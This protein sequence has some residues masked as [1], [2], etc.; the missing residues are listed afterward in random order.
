MYRERINDISVISVLDIRK[1]KKSGKYPVRIQVAYKGVQ[2]Y[3]NTGKDLTKE[4]WAKLPNTRSAELLKLRDSIKMYFDLIVG[5]VEE[6]TSKGEYSFDRLTV[7]I[8]KNSGGTLNSAFKVKIQELLEE[9]RIG[10]MGYYKDCLVSVEKYAG[11]NI[12]F[13]DVNIQ[14]LNKFERFLLKNEMSYASIGMRM[15]GIRT[16]MNIAKNEGLIK[17]IQ[18]PFGRGKYEI[19]TAAGRKKALSMAQLSQVLAYNDGDET[20]RRYRDIWFFIYLCNGINVADLVRLKFSDIIDG[21]ICFMRQKTARTSNLKKEITVPITPQ[22]QDIID[23]WGN[24]PHPGNYLFNLIPH[25]KDPIRHEIEVE[26]LIKHINNR[27]KMIG[28]KLGIGKI[29][30]YTARHTFATVLK[31]SGANL[32]YIQESLG[33]SD[34]R[35][36]ENYLAS[37]EQDERRKNA[38]LLT[39][40]LKQ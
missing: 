20:T 24:K 4:E 27:M 12:P 6:L 39:S 37:F 15:R 25:T 29:T 21:E 31:R 22:M 18:Y 30:T 26:Y 11:K 38:D 8:G 14:W 33:H 19:K 23:R 1:I 35:T 2:K 5:S 32:L 16:M 10:T 9:A 3:L 17:E 34:P 40:F 28:E 13:T 36:T 7:L